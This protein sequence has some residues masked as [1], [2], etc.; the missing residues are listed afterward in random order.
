MDEDFKSNPL[1]KNV[2]DYLLKPRGKIP[3]NTS[4]Q[5]K[6]FIRRA[7]YIICLI[8]ASFLALGILSWGINYQKSKFTNKSLQVTPSPEAQATLNSE[9]PQ[10][11][12]CKNF[13]DLEE[14]LK[15]VDIA[16]GLDLSGKG[17]T[18]VPPEVFKLSKL[19]ELN[20]SRNNIAT[21]SAELLNLPGLYSLDL[22]DNKITEVSAALEEKLNQVSG[23]RIP[24]Q[25]LKLTGNNI[26]ILEQSKI[27]QLLP[28]VRMSF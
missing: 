13:S 20:L 15:N 9:I 28:N 23:S 5:R 12:I 24:L 14:A 4:Y 16:C 6:W 18:S 11:I 2:M 1:Y 8:F 10:K 25:S 21:F 7:I 19:N 26:G 27:K 22:S 17:L 3:Q